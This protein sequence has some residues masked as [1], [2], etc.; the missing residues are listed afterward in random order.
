MNVLGID[1]GG[2][3]TV[4]LL[5]DDSGTV[6]GDARGPGAN[7]QSAG[8]LEVEK[9]LHDVIGRALGHHPQPRAICLGMAGVDRPGEAAT[10]RQILERIGHRARVLVVNDALIALEAGVPGGAGTVVV[11][12]TGSIAY[13][14]DAAGRAARSGGWGYVLG[15]EG[16]AYWL[17]S[18]ALR[19]VVR[20][21]DGRGAP[22]A[23]AEPILSHFGVTKPQDLVR[24]IYVAGAR[25]SSIAALAKIVGAAAVAGDAA[26]G[27]L[28]SLGGRELAMAAASVASR[29]GIER[30]PVL[31]AG[32]TLRG[33]ELLRTSLTADLGRRLP[34]ADVRL[35][36]IEPAQGAV[37]LAQAEA[38]GT[39][40]LPAYED[41][42]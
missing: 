36:S 38:L 4:C 34:G 6:L 41:G 7:L 22:T 11:A 15:D 8:E 27:E 32:S 19:A 1:A 14:R 16:S 3:R 21:A 25:P 20:A 29:L 33:L 39:L 13:G 37:R 23:M 42:F 30:E 31:L 5:V 28:I 24:H 26:A 9:V 18:L 2:T 40:Q 12:G 10:I 35:L 17:G